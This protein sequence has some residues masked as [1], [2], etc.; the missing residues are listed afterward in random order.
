MAARRVRVKATN[1]SQSLGRL[2][3][4]KTRTVTWLRAIEKLQPKDVPVSA[5]MY[6]VP[7]SA[8]LERGHE[9]QQR[10]EETGGKRAKIARTRLHTPLANWGAPTAHVEYT[11]SFCQ[12]PTTL[13]AMHVRYNYML[14]LPYTVSCDA[15]VS[16][17]GKT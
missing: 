15:C 10:A 5:S 3:H 8:L 6:T 1:V 16:L 13:D 2:T 7:P 14:P 4:V 17:C 11:C 9:T 12:L